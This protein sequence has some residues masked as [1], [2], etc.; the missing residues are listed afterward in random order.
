MS[1][2]AKPPPDAPILRVSRPWFRPRSTLRVHR[3]EGLRAGA[4]APAATVTL[5]LA[6]AA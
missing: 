2:P 3:S 5:M 6:L 1:E 4:V